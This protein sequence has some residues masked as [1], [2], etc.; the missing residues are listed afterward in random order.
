MVSHNAQESES[1][2]TQSLV[3]AAANYCP[4]RPIGD[5]LN[6]HAVCIN[7]GSVISTCFDIIYIFFYESLCQIARDT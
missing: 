5:G 7:E 3:A 6:I 4:T 1:T 2:N